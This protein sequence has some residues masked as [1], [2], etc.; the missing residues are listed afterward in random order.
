M[1][2]QRIMIAINEKVATYITGGTIGGNT[3]VTIASFM[4]KTTPIIVYLISLFTL[5][6]TILLCIYWFKKNFKK[7][8]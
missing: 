6:M 8:G 3:A 4:D 5:I 7:E 2:N 1:I